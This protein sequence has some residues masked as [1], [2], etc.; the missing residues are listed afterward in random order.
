MSS[1]EILFSEFEKSYGPFAGFLKI[2]NQYLH[3]D[4]I[5]Y[6]ITNKKNSLITEVLD[7]FMEYSNSSLRIFYTHEYFNVFLVLCKLEL[8]IMIKFFSNIKNSKLYSDYKTIFEH[9]RLAINIV[10]N[11]NKLL[12][13]IESLEMEN[14]IK[15]KKIRELELQIR[16]MP[17]GE[18]YEKAK[19]H[20]ESLQL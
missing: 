17:G 8:S 7:D 6:I 10:K 15:D 13:R 11:E 20:F 9:L 14:E 2:C 5:E 19:E 1:L 4:I 12:R 16:Y 3:N 18:E